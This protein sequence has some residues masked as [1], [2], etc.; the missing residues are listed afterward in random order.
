M[1]IFRYYPDDHSAHDHDLDKKIIRHSIAFALFFVLLF[2]LVRILEEVFD[3][4]LYKGGIYPLH[5]KGIPGIITSPFIHSGFGHLISNSVPFALLLFFLVYYYRSLSYRI[6][7]QIYL[8]SGLCVWLAGREAWHIGASGVVYGLAAFHFTSGVIRNDLRLLVISIVVVFLYGG[9]V[10]GMMPIKPEISWE[11]HLWGGISGLL[12][13]F[14]YKRYTIRRRKFSWEE[15]PET[16]EGE[17]DSLSTTGIPSP[18][19]DSTSTGDFVLKD[20]AREAP[21]LSEKKEGLEG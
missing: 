3:L 4:S 16:E 12:L 15:E 11:S 17:P 20:D 18:F 7:I 9:M 2:W 13:A 1:G 21:P 6:F 5:L 19:S 10:W 8:L 14:F